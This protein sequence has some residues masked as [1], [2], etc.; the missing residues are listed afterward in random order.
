MRIRI[1]RLTEFTCEFSKIYDKT[2]VIVL[3]YDIRLYIRFGMKTQNF[4]QAAYKN[5]LLSDFYVETSRSF[6]NKVP[7]IANFDATDT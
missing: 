7:F 5:I 3:S 6:G 2:F 4:W 1:G